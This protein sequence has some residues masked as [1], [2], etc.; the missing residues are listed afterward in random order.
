MLDFI[1]R[2]GD[3]ASGNIRSKSGGSPRVPRT[4]LSYVQSPSVPIARHG[5]KQEVPYKLMQEVHVQYSLPFRLAAGD[6][7]E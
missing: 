4:K 1:Y 3:M 7:L 6:A 5:T 2:T